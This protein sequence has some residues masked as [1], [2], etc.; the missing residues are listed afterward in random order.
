MAK[1][2]KKVSADFIDKLDQNFLREQYIDVPHT[3]IVN[4]AQIIDPSKDLGVRFGVNRINANRV[5]KIEEEFGPNGESIYGV[6]GD[7]FDQIR[8][9]GNILYR[10]DGSG[11][12]IDSRLDNNTDFVEITFYGT[13]LNWLGFFNGSE[14]YYSVDGGAEN[15][16]IDSTSQAGNVLAGRTFAANN[17]VNVVSELS[18]GIHTVKIR[19]ESGAAVGYFNFSGFEILN[20]RSDILIPQGDYFKNGQ[21]LRHISEES[22][23]YASV[24]ENSYGTLGTKGGHV[25]VYLND[26]GQI[27]KDIQYTDV[28]AQFIGAT[29]HTNEEIIGKYSFGEFGVGNSDDFSSLVNAD[30]DRA[31]TLSDGTTTLFGDNCQTSNGTSLRP[32]SGGSLT[33][34]FVGTGLDYTQLRDD[35]A[36]T[37]A[38]GDL[39]VDDVLVGSF[40][41]PEAGGTFKVCSGLP[42]G[43]HT[44]TFDSVSNSDALSEFIVYGPKKPEINENYAELGHYFLMADFVANTTAKWDA[45][46]QGTL[47]KCNIKEFNYYGAWSSTGITPIARTSG[48]DIRTTTVSNYFEYWF[49]GTGFDFRLDSNGTTTIEIDGSTDHSSLATSH[50]G[51]GTWTPAAGTIVGNLTNSEGIVINGLDLGLHKVKVTLTAGT[52]LFP[53]SLDIITPIHTPKVTGP[54][55]LQSTSRVGSQAIGDSRKVLKADSKSALSEGA[56]GSSYTST[57]LSYFVIPDLLNIIHLEEETEVIVNFSGSVR[58]NNGGE[59]LYMIFFIDNKAVGKE[60]FHQENSSAISYNNLAMDY[61][62][63]L[64]KGTHTIQV[65]YRVGSGTGTITNSRVLKTSKA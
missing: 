43:T 62:V 25:V 48:I 29:D 42:Y 3:Q 65:A 57:S 59:F 1:T 22:I 39:Y 52:A 51:T 16:L 35:L 50:Y 53:E 47:R 54:F 55:S 8:F 34:V 19:R 17:V 15:L 45:I 61:K 41:R 31:Y 24:F 49:F 13:G 44:V 6:D 38:L 28:S 5:Y 58:N 23:P 26:K 33:F 63:T 36:S 37:G 7:K 27:K 46:S 20:E 56:T 11:P 60:I 18:L 12:R 40:A 9:V 64:S 21:L 10:N 32:S 30:S 2:S 4:R 14:L